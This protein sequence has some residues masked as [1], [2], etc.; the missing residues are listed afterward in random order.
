MGWLAAADGHWA[1]G[2]SGNGYA[3][4][5]AGIGYPV[6]FETV[7]LGDE[8]I[9]P[10]LGCR[11]C[12]NRGEE[13]CPLAD[14]LLTLKEKMKAADAVIIASPVYVNDVSGTVKMWID[15]LAHTCHRPEFAGKCALLVATAGNGPTKHALRTMH[16]ALSQWGFFIVGQAGFKTGALMKQAEM[17]AQY[18]KKTERIAWNIYQAIAEQKFLNP[19]FLSLMTFKIQQRYWQRSAGESIDYAYWHNR[20]W[21]VS[22]RSY[23][24]DH[25]ANPIKVLLARLSGSF[26]ARFVT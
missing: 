6:E 18:R 8:D 7:Y 12:F 25:Q 9:R 16:M 24:T 11:S 4:V 13:W 22:R 10:C 26:L 15:R 1:N 23:Y 5:A 17:E 14:D 19:S 2:Q 3:I 20:G 21:T